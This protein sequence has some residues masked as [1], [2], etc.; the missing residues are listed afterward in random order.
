MHVPRAAS[1]QVC[2]ACA[3]LVAAAIPLVD[4]KADWTDVEISSAPVQAVPEGARFETWVGAQAFSHAW[5]LYSGVTAAPFSAISEDGMRL[6]A[7]G[8]YGTYSYSGARPVTSAPVRFGGVTEFGDILVGYQKQLG[9]VTLK[10]F[11]GLAVANNVITPEDPE[12][13]IRGLGIGAKGT[14]EAW[15]TISDRVW[16]SADLSWATV[17]D[18]YSARGRVGWRLLP[19]WSTGLEVG[20]A[21]NA[22]SDTARV[23]GFLRCEW[24][25][26]ELSASGG[27]SSDRLLEGAPTPALARS[28]TPFVTFSWLTRF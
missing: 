26:G 5:S 8:G 7:S 6:R 16:S 4:A 13:A 17:H 14:V 20:A 23:G 28:S 25:A 24:A 11:A 10:G 1:R 15:W 19:D 27:W 12:T 2:R 9:P 22:E 18:S 21:G 3:L